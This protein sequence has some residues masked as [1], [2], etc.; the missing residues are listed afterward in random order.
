MSLLDKNIIITPNKGQV[1]D[2]QIVFSGADSVTSAQNIT[3]KI[4]PDD[5]GTLLFEGSGGVLFKIK[6]LLTGTIFSVN[7][8]SGIPSI[9]VLDTG[10]IKLGEFGGNVLLGT[11]TD[12]TTDKLQVTGTVA[13]GGVNFTEGTN[14]DQVKT[15]TKSILLTTDWQDTGIKSTDLATGTYLVQLFASDIGQGGTNN[16][17][18]YSGTM[19]W[20]SGDTNSALEM[21]TDEIPLHRSGASGDGALYLRTYR[22]PTADPDN[23]KLQIYSNTA[24]SSPANYVFKFRRMI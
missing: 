23:L 15:I 10:Q 5:N 12:N 20:Y 9:E 16:T 22:T 19:S 4:I 6:N 3:L 7:D 8:I 13:H 24:N 14:T 17:E 11:G 2:P 21:P 1:G 18:R